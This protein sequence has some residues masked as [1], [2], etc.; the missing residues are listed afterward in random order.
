MNPPEYGTEIIPT[1]LHG[2]FMPASASVEVWEEPLGDG[3]S[4]YVLP[5]GGT[6][7]LMEEISSKWSRDFALSVLGRIVANLSRVCPTCGARAVLEG[8]TIG[9]P[10]FTGKM[11]HEGQCP[12][13]DDGLRAARTDEPAGP[14]PPGPRYWI[15][16]V[17][18][19]RPVAP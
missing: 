2:P 6:A 19:L 9:G 10:G 16:W 18:R 12:L 11:E 14:I 7:C 8:A 13:S 1:D 3:W 4:L 15:V 5:G 17:P